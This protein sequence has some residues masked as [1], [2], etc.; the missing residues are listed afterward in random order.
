MEAVD[1]E[2]QLRWSINQVEHGID[3]FKGEFGAFLFFSEDGICLGLSLHSPSVIKCSTSGSF[4]DSP[5]EHAEVGSYLRGRRRQAIQIESFTVETSEFVHAFLALLRLLL[6]RFWSRVERED[7]RVSELRF[8]MQWDID[9][10]QLVL[11]VVYRAN[12][13]IDNVTFARP[14]PLHEGRTQCERAQKQQKQ[15][16]HIT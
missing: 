15:A 11:E 10:R 16:L 6:R 5:A 1:D 12:D 9:L 14:R 3:V 7:V 2:D 13:V 4:S 8:F